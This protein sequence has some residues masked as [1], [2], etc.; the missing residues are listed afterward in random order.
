[1]RFARARRFLKRALIAGLA[2]VCLFAAAAVA[3]AVHCSTVRGRFQPSAATQAG[4]GI[5]GYARPEDGTFLSYAEWYIV[6]SYQEKAAWQQA[7]L[8]S[9]FPYFSA[10]GQYWSGYCCSYGVVHGRYP[11]NFGDHLM[12][13]VIGTSFTV[14]YGLKGAYENT[15]GR[16]AE[17]SGG[18]ELSEDDRYAARVARD[19]GVFVQ[20]RPFYEFPFFGAFR[21]LW[22]DTKLWGPH[23]LRK[24][25]RKAWLSLDYG[26]EAVYCGLIELASHAAYGV[27]DDVTYALI[28]NAPET[29]LASIP[30]V[31]KVKSA[32][33]NSFIIAMPRYQKFTGAAGQLLRA[34]ARFV[35]IAGNRQ[36]MVTAVVPR[37]WSFQL[38][39]SELLFS[40]EILTGPQ[41]KRVALR[42]PVA[43]LGSIAG[44][45]SLEHIYDY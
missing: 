31:H 18:Q 27:E 37:D 3:F 34:Q 9:G 4:N 22:T 43:D 39:A 32:G 35:E 26:I 25:E 1:V 7:H 5:P 45:L 11:F 12:L 2:A 13:A 41:S 21:G 10:I 29:V 19:Y 30:A 33:I 40:S 38:P 8:P 15:V 14:E 17:W 23:V 20:D 24:W 36:I 42:A 28:E 16:L 44:V 6:W